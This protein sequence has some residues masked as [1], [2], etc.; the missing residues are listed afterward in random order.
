MRDP[1]ARQHLRR[2]EFLRRL[3]ALTGAAASAQ[4]V[5]PQLANPGTI[6]E[7]REMLEAA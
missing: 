2:R 7:A 1:H 5:H 4:R 6:R 3:M